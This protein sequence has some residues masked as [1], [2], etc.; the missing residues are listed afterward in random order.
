[1]DIK[2][3]SVVLETM[4]LIKAGITAQDPSGLVSKSQLLTHGFSHFYI[5]AETCHSTGRR[6]FQLVVTRESA[7]RNSLAFKL[8]PALVASFIPVAG[9]LPA[10]A[11]DECDVHQDEHDQL[12]AQHRQIHELVDDGVIS[13]QE[14]AALDA[15]LRAEHRAFHQGYGG[16]FNGYGYPGYYNGNQGYYGSSWYNSGWWNPNRNA[17]RA[18]HRI[19]NAEH[20]DIHRLVRQGLISPQEHAAIDARLE[21]QHEQNDFEHGWWGQND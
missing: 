8:L 4:A 10:L 6:L 20:R 21:A 3:G 1:M 14:H 7:M 18:E 2:D 9:M 19:L 15:R 13:P 5:Q 17:H 12:R 16:Y 11:H